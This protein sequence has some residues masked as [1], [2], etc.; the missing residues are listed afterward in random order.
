MWASLESE[1]YLVALLPLENELWVQ[2]DIFS[3]E[4]WGN[5]Y[6]HKLESTTAFFIH[7]FACSLTKETLIDVY[8]IH[9]LFWEL[10]TGIPTTTNTPIKELTVA[11][12]GRV[13]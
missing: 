10:D 8:T 4:L 5:N 3:N 7:V 1:L 2:I 6:L 11:G 13:H 9:T 12:W